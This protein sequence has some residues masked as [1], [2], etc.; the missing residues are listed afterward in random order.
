MA[1]ERV[2]SIF[3]AAGASDEELE[4]VR[5]GLEL[6]RRGLMSAEQA[7]YYL[8]GVARELLVPLTPRQVGDLRE[9][10]GLP[11]SME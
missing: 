2:S 10:L 8:M 6:W 9:A 1:E 3:R 5:R 4:L 11:R 7:Y